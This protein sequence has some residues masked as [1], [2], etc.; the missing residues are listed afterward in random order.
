M[1][2][3]NIELTV[4]LNPCAND[5]VT[6]PVQDVTRQQY[7]ILSLVSI[8]WDRLHKHMLGGPEAKWWPLK[9]LNLLWGL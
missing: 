3:D 8:L 4:E 9:V 7:E 1:I 5:S 2:F 6:P